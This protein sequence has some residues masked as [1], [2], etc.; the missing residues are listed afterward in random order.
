MRA[1]SV[2]RSWD[3]FPGLDGSRVT[4]TLVATYRFPNCGQSDNSLEP[5]AGIRF[6]LFDGTDRRPQFN[7][8]P[9]GGKYVSINFNVN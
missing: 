1:S 7:P 2:R 4:Q 8:A 9:G 5:R 3:Y 6:L